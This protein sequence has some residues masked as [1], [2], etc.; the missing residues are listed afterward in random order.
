MSDSRS[1]P[2]VQGVEQPLLTQAELRTRFVRLQRGG[3]HETC[4]L[5]ETRTHF[6]AYC[7]E[8]TEKRRQ[9]RRMVRSLKIRV[10]MN[11][12]KALL[13][14]PKV[15]PQYYPP[16]VTGLVLTPNRRGE[17][18]ASPA[19]PVDYTETEKREEEKRGKSRSGL[20][21][22]GPKKKFNPLRTGDRLGARLHRG[23]VFSENVVK[24]GADPGS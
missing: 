20:T 19:Y 24:G 10:D 9:F 21:D 18:S 5:V 22:A 6:L 11:S 15:F 23:R 14:N 1:V 4:N 17:A 13:D 16:G 12:T 7:K 3:A 8:N 2:P